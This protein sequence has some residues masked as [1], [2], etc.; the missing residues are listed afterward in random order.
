MKISSNNKNFAYKTSVPQN[1]SPAFGI[2]FKIPA[3][4]TDIFVKRSFSK[5]KGIDKIKNLHPG[6][7]G[8]ECNHSVPLQ[9]FEEQFGIKELKNLYR[10][11]L[12]TNTEAWADAFLKSSADKPLSTSSV[13]DC[14]VMY[15]FNKETNTH[16]LYHS[17]FQSAK[18]RFDFLLKTFM[19]EG[20]TKAEILPGINKW[21]KRHKETLPEMLK[22]LRECS[23]DAYISVRHYS[24]K[25][26]EIVGYN[27][28]LYEIPNR[29]IQMGFYD[30]GQASFDICDLKAMTLVEE[31]KK[32]A[33]NLKKIPVMRQLYAQ[34]GYDLEILKIINRIIQEQLAK[35][36]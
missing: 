21:F 19:P 16:F 4:I 11:G 34:N 33:Q 23:P 6:K 7:F 36:G 29:R 35:F 3:P 14:S 12:S 9:N 15:V 2:S 17:A 5:E 28:N 26:P 8:T 27:G 18:N 13:Y 25:M 24:T 22:S 32:N 20:F 10:K 1:C 31:I 30:R